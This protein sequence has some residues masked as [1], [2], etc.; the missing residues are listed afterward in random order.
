MRRGTHRHAPRRPRPRREHRLHPR[1]HRRVRADPRRGRRRGLGGPGSLHRARRPARGA[2]RDSLGQGAAR[3][4][5]RPR[6]GDA[7]K[8]SADARRSRLGHPRVAGRQE[9]KAVRED[10]RRV[11]A[12]ARGGARTRLAAARRLIP[13]GARRALRGA[14]APPRGQASRRRESVVVGRSRGRQ[15]KTLNA[16]GVQSPHNPSTALGERAAQPGRDGPLARGARP[17]PAPRN[18][19]LSCAAQ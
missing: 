12:H 3:A 4:V 10:P 13:R 16:C 9:A 18:Q 2:V 8:R 17:P 11:R 7:G 1:A 14:L 15:R 6:E 5:S 19:P